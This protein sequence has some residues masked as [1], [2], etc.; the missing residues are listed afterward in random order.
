LL[1]K[2]KYLC[3]KT[4]KHKNKKTTKKTPKKQTN[5]K[6][7]IIFIKIGPEMADLHLF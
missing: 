2:T 5:K 4:K 6:N 3:G 1:E 7:R